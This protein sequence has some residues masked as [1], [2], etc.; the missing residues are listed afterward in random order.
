MVDHLDQL[1]NFD[2]NGRGVGTLHSAALE[3]EG[4]PLV[5][6]AA[7]R[8]ASLRP[9]TRVIMTTGM[10]TRPWVS[11]TAIE[12][13]GPAG[14]AVLARALAIGV[15]AVPVV[16]AEAET[17]STL[18][19]MLRAAGLTVVSAAAAG[20]PDMAQAELRAYPEDDD[21]ALAAAAPTLDAIDPGALVSVERAG[22]NDRGVYHNARGQDISLGK[23]RLDFLF[24]EAGRR[25]LPTIGVGDG[26]NEIGMGLVTDAVLDHVPCGARCRCGCGGGV[27]AVTATGVLVTAGV[28]N[29]ACYGIAACLAIRL[30]RMDLLHTPDEEERLLRYGVDLGLLDAPRGVIDP[31]VDGIPLP[32]HMAMVQ[33]IGEL[34]RRAAAG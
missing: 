17:L 12:N 15:S 27:A 4:R 2:L 28:S 16:V 3:R 22:R 5:D 34:A 30:G 21:A 1:V 10:A 33:L 8:L 23:A 19:S 25:G 13:D 29:W 20:P 31:D 32:T 7:E 24:G 18:G 26:G 11:T 6:A 9:G 14:T